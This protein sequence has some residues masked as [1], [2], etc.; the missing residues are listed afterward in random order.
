MLS[1]PSRSLRCRR[2]VDARACSA[3]GGTADIRRCPQ[4]TQMEPRSPRGRSAQVN[5]FG[6]IPILGRR[7][8]ADYQRVVHAG[9]VRIAA[10]G[11]RMM[12]PL[13]QAITD[14]AFGPI[15]T[16][17]CPGAPGQPSPRRR[18]LLL[19]RFP[20][21]RLVP[22]SG[23]RFWGLST[24]RNVSLRGAGPQ[25]WGT[26]CRPALPQSSSLK[27]VGTRSP[28]SGAASRDAEPQASRLG[29]GCSLKAP[30]HELGFKS[31]LEWCPRCQ[32]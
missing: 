9:V 1:L 19:R 17:R 22:G 23:P 25:P 4:I 31:C 3:E 27:T 2:P 13:G 24:R 11:M 10:R 20:L 5:A 32:G 12:D 6:P 14:D 26:R 28:C 7:S 15:C 21:A 30:R 29:G 8:L 18:W 16:P